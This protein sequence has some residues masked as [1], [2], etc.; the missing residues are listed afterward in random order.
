VSI[1]APHV[2]E[3]RLLD[4]YLAERGDEPINPR[5]AEHLADCEAC[6]VR[7]A[8]FTQFMDGLR[9]EADVETDA[10]FTPERLRS[11]QLQIARRIEHVGRAARV[12]SFPGRFVSR[13][14]D[15]SSSHIAPRWVAAAAAAGLVFGLAAGASF[16][17]DRHV[18]SQQPLSAAARST[19]AESL[20]PIAPRTAN[21]AATTDDDA[22]LSELEV[23]LERP[24]T[25]ELQPFDA[26]T[27]HVREIA[28]PIR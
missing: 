8:E 2:Q 11:Q 6:A 20:A 16:E 4:C 22:F 27:P 18:R 25:R 19:A 7:Y 12:I 28:N 24:H 26:F 23:S 21:A 1:R 13:H 14:M 3:E 9:L 10:I 17:W 15:V 5:I